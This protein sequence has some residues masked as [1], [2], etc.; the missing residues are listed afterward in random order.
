MLK[1]FRDRVRINKNLVPEKHLPS[2]IAYLIG[3]PLDVIDEELEHGS[4]AGPG[5]EGRVGRARLE[6]PL[7]AAAGDL[8]RLL[9]EP[10][11]EDPREVAV[12][13]L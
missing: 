4:Q 7:D 11:L 10:H 13:R 12:G 3:I 8:A 9:R 1:Y 2:N 5:L 6:R